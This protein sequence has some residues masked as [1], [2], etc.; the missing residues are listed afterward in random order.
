M[1]IPVGSPK[2]LPMI[3]FVPLTRGVRKNSLA[4]RPCHY[5][6]RAV[7]AGVADEADVAIDGL[8]VRQ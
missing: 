4:G 1:G 6:M 2:G 8:A 7:S 3:F 5:G